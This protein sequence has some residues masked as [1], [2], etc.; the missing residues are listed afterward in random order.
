MRC[1]TV[2]LGLLLPL[3]VQ[4]QDIVDVLQRS[5][6]ARV[7]QHGTADAD[8]VAA[9]RVRSSFA[10]VQALLPGP[11]A[12]PP[13]ELVL[14]GGDLYAEALFGRRAMAVSASVGELPEGERLML[15]AHEM[16]HL[17]LGH[18]GA[19]SRLYLDLIPGEVRPETTDPVTRQLS[20]QAHALSHRHEFEADRYGYMVVRRLGFGLDNASGLL[21]RSGLHFDS[22][23]HPGTRRRLAQ[24]RAV[25][26]EVGRG[27]LYAVEA[28]T[29][30]ARLAQP[31]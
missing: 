23:T 18:W 29:L 5:Q 1:W 22:P 2:V 13:V 20:A 15:L 8:S 16:G 26:L 30:A 24:L 28:E 7:A 9:T 17:V 21:L 19:L 3:V 11:A 14:V 31:D 25:D 10:R 27:A 12:S 4:A 6:M